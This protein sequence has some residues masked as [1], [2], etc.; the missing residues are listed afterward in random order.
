MEQAG[1]AA[2]DHF[3]SV[4]SIQ[5][6]SI[7]K[8]LELGAHTL[9][10]CILGPA[11]LS[12]NA[13]HFI[14]EGCQQQKSHRTH[15]C[16]SA[17][18]HGPIFFYGSFVQCVAKL[19]KVFCFSALP[20]AV[21]SF[22]RFSNFPATFSLR[23]PDLNASPVLSAY[24]TSTLGFWPTYPVRPAPALPGDFSDWIHSGVITQSHGAPKPPA[25][26]WLGLTLQHHNGLTDIKRAGARAKSP[27]LPAQNT[28]ICLSVCLS[29]CLSLSFGRK[30]CPCK[31]HLQVVTSWPFFRILK[32]LLDERLMSSEKIMKVHLL[33]IET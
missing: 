21:A 3:I 15:T 23:H 12:W 8:C 13:N 25:C 20:S 2:A 28:S 5:A 30:D 22:P 18:Q 27:W 29:L 32:S 4:V 26:E 10:G 14:P 31:R 19:Q 1:A 33:W 17:I 11:A 24:F 16:K 6:E 9:A 7:T